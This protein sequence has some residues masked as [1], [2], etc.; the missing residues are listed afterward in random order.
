MFLLFD[1]I[2]HAYRRHQLRRRLARIDW[3]IQDIRESRLRPESE[4]YQLA[5]QEKSKE[6]TLK[7]HT[8]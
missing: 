7:E 1:R 2:R 8:R 5:S 4:L 3:N 6:Q